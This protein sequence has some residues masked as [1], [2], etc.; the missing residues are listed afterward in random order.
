M[1]LEATL[2]QRAQN[3][4]ATTQKSEGVVD[5]VAQMLKSN[6]KAIQS[7]IPAHVTPERLTRVSLTVI[8]GNRDLLECTPL[9]LVGAIM[10]CVRYGFEPNVGGEAYIIPYRNKK[11]GGRKEARFQLGYIGVA[12]LAYRS[13]FVSGVGATEV[14]ENDEYVFA[15]GPGMKPFVR[16]AIGERGKVLFYFAWVELTNGGYLWDYM[17]KA[18]V[19]AHRD[20]FS[21][22]PDGFGWRDNFDSMAKKTV[23]LKVLKLAPKSVEMQAA[24]LMDGKAADPKRIDDVAAYVLPDDES[25]EPDEDEPA[26]A[27]AKE[28]PA[29][30]EDTAP[31]SEP[32]PEPEP[33]QEE[34]ETQGSLLE[35]ET[36][37]AEPE[38]GEPDFRVDFEKVSDRSTLDAIAT[39]E[40][41]DE[42]NLFVRQNQKA[43]S[44]L[45][46][47]RRA[48]F[49]KAIEK[50]KAAISKRK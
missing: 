42:L 15:Y 25:M 36:V 40:A 8:S 24:F 48:A 3:G 6:W 43:I 41:M 17:T 31:E 18:E 50:Q 19:D 7:T 33:E 9:S 30:T 47:A 34:R 45:P 4:I 21:K 35:P 29:A 32:E 37:E 16:K 26:P 20:H 46:P 38:S 14:C 39:I 10:Q 49:M 1:S 22:Q 13:G 11:T 27:E 5:S 23:L 12:Q 44:A 28:I 2:Q